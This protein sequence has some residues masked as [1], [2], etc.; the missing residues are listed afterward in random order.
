MTNVEKTSYF[1]VARP[2]HTISYKNI[3]DLLKND[4]LKMMS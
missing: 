1:E 3:D 2:G 4:K